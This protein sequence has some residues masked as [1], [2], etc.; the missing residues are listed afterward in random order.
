[1]LLINI[2]TLLF[3][4]NLPFGNQH[5]K[6][7]CQEKKTNLAPFEEFRAL[8][9]KRAEQHHNYLMLSYCKHCLV[10]KFCGVCIMIFSVSI[11]FNLGK[12]LFV[13]GNILFLI[14]GFRLLFSCEQLL[15]LNSV[16]FHS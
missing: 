16:I 3:M 6:F 15:H 10:K 7:V 5:V 13:C 8:K 11:A 1:M 9:P 12:A 4:I 2:Y 14:L